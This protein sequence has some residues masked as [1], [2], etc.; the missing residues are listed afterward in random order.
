MLSKFTRHIP[1]ANAITRGFAHRS[2]DG[3]TGWMVER[4][5]LLGTLPKQAFILTDCHQNERVHAQTPM[6]QRLDHLGL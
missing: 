4:N 1:H 6:P 5:E 3:F 2:L